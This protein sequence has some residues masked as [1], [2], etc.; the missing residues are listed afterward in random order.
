MDKSMDCETGGCEFDPHSGETFFFKLKIFK[1]QF[2]AL[3][4]SD[5]DFTFAQS[6]SSMSSIIYQKIDLQAS[7]EHG[8]KW[9]RLWK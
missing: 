2:P 8:Q 6:K 1:G 5:A 3:P 7:P 9:D 4:S